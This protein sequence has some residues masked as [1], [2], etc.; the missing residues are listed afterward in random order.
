MAR[1]ISWSSAA[2]TLG[3]SLSLAA[4]PAFADGWGGHRKHRHNDG[5]DAGDIFAG[6]LVIGAIAAIASAVSKSQ[7]DRRERDDRVRDGSSSSGE[8]AYPGGPARDD[9][10]RY[11]EVPGGYPA[12]DDSRAGGWRVSPGLNSAVDNCVAEIERADRKVDTVDTVERQASGWRVS[13]Q[14]NGG[15]QFACMVDGDGRIRSATVDGQAAYPGG[16][17]RP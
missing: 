10:P 5:V 9:A 8:Y 17:E 11:S 15:R 12:G 3:A 6:V 7:K 13:G 4:T 1:R 2:L 14:V 16:G